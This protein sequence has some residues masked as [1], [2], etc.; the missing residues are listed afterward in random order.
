MTEH[1]NS[2]PP[3]GGGSD[4]HPYGG[5]GDAF[6]YAVA[7]HPSRYRTLT[8]A[9]ITALSAWFAGSAS[10]PEID[11]A[12]TTVRK[13]LAA[14]ELLLSMQLERAAAAAPPVPDIVSRAIL[15]SAAP[16]KSAGT[17]FG[18]EARKILG[19]LV[20]DLGAAFG[21]LIPATA[22]TRGTV[23][24][25]KGGNSRP[26]QEAFSFEEFD[27][28]TTL[29]EELFHMRIQDGD[30][31]SSALS[32]LKQALLGTEHAE[33]SSMILD[34][35]VRRYILSTAASEFVALWCFDLE[36]PAN[37][38]LASAVSD[39]PHDKTILVTLAH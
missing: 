12:R 23:S 37:A 8:D 7:K 2:Q 19:F 13:N 17:F 30:A 4:E 6:L 22:A 18:I 24:S 25:E 31:A 9:E 20:V 14:K 27:V 34:A 5:A 28:P 33:A 35:E 3:N 1:D 32:R 26:T 15:R 21:G 39:P 10:A 16:Q 36:N 11:V 29:L 38:E